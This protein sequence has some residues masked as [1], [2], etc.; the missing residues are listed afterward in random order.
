MCIYCEYKTYTIYSIYSLFLILYMVYRNNYSLNFL[1][2]KSHNISIIWP[3]AK[4]IVITI[5]FDAY[6]GSVHTIC[7]EIISVIIAVKC[8]IGRIVFFVRSIGL[9]DT[10]SCSKMRTSLSEYQVH[11]FQ[12]SFL[13]RCRLRLLKHHRARNWYLE[14]SQMAD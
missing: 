1:I 4:C 2:S 7:D 11:I 13:R 8:C 5:S 10:H 9:C 6:C 12:A 14:S 3:T